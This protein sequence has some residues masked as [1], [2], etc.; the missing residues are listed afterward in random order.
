VVHALDDTDQATAALKTDDMSGRAIFVG[1]PGGDVASPFGERPGAIVH[2]ANYY[3]MQVP[4]SSGSQW[5]AFAIDVAVGVCLAYI[6]QWS[7]A[8]GRR[9]AAAVPGACS[10][11]GRTPRMASRGCSLASLLLLGTA[12]VVLTWVAAVCSA[13]LN[14]RVDPVPVA[15]AMFLSATL[16]VWAIDR[17]Q[18]ISATPE[19][20]SQLVR[21]GVA[22][23]VIA[24]SCI[25][26]LASVSA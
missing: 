25:A 8:A 20:A 13:R 24:S 6:F 4:I 14:V 17:R 5:T 11:Q 18:R 1:R 16:R 2:A 23:V 26:M 10:R 15:V 12:V 19:P 9:V 22:I 21:V 3:S 7:H